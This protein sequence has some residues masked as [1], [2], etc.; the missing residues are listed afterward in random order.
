MGRGQKACARYEIES[1]WWI[2]SSFDK[3]KK[4]SEAR[5]WL[6]QFGATCELKDGDKDFSLTVNHG[7]E[8]LT[9]ADKEHIV[10]WTGHDSRD[11]EWVDR[12]AVIDRSE[13]M[14][15][16]TE[17][18]KSIQSEQFTTKDGEIELV[19]SGMKITIAGG[20][21]NDRMELANRIK[22]GLEYGTP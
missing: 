22:Q 5:E 2:C 6:S 7:G 11:G 15:R 3:D 10:T 14:N 8:T 12:F 18:Q 4:L 9:V 20:F 17:Y 21:P 13:Y 1:F 19:S 16:Y